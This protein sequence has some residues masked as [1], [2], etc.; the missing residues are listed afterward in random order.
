MF[1]KCKE[2]RDV[3]YIADP[4]TRDSPDNG[5]ASDADSGVAI[6]QNYSTS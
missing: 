5:S 4:V 6:R 3:V 2:T 1:T